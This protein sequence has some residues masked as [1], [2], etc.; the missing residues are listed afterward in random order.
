MSLPRLL[1]IL[2][3]NVGV[4]F[5]HATDSPAIIARLPHEGIKPSAAFDSA[6]VLHLVYFSGPTDGGDAFYVTSKDHGLNFSTPLRVNSQVKSVMGVSSIRGPRMALGKDGAVH[7][8]WNGVSEA[9]PK[10]P[11]NPALPTDS[12]FNGIPLLYTRLDESRRAFEP[13]RNLMEKSCS[14]DGGS[15]ITAD[16]SGNVYAIWHAMPL[17]G[18]KE[19]DRTVWMRKSTDN[20]K[21]FADETSILPAPSG[22]CGCCSLAAQ[23]SPAGEIAVLFRSAAGDGMERPMNLLVSKDHG[24]TFSR[25]ALDEWPLKMCPMSSESVVPV[26]RGFAYAWEGKDGLRLARADLSA[27]LEDA[28]KPLIVKTN[29]GKPLKYPSV[30]T[31]QRGD[32]LFVWTEG[33][34]WNRGGNL[35]WEVFDATGMQSLGT[36]RVENIPANDSPLALS[37]PDGRFLILY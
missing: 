15:T 35:L 36:G 23:S 13:Q 5:C 33:M 32:I 30:A 37:Q 1:A 9:L 17:T 10:A 31:N 25:T 20:G 14:I 21:T 26:T 3:L 22:V 18:G 27:S 12:K 16:D 2:F 4:A 8:L 24:T 28:T 19:S 7:V 29:A 11:L 6:G 34:G